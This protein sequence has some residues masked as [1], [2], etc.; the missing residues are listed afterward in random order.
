[1]ITYW[2]LQAGVYLQDDFRVSKSLTLS[3]GVRFETQTHV[4]DHNNFAPRFG[5]TWAPFKGGKTTLRGSWGIF[6]DWLA[7]GTYEQTLRVD[8]VRQQELDIFDPSY[9]DPGSGGI[10]TATNQYR[11]TGNLP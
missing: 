2:N 3:P 10:E 7:P 9:P 1:L 4:G 5:I 11:L 6:Y 8:G